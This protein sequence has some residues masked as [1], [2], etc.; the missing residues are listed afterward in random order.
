MKL[1]DY[2][3]S[4]K[5]KTIFNKMYLIVIF[6]IIII[7][8]THEFKTKSSKN[9]F[10]L[11]K[12]EF[13]SN[14]QENFTNKAASLN[15]E[16]YTKKGL[17]ELNICR[18]E[19]NANYNR[20]KRFKTCN[21]CDA[22][23]GCSWCNEKKAC[24]PSEFNYRN[25]EM[26]PICQGECIKLIKIEYCYKGLFEP[27]ITQHEIN[28]SNYKDVLEESDEKGSDNE[29][30]FEKELE[31][32]FLQIREGN[33]KKE[34]SEIKMNNTPNYQNYKSG[35]KDFN[36]KQKD[37]TFEDKN[38]D[39][40]PDKTDVTG[41]LRIAMNDPSINYIPNAFTNTPSQI[42]LEQSRKLMINKMNEI[43]KN[44]F[45][46][47][48]DGKLRQAS[49]PNFMPEPND[50]MKYLK[51]Y[52]PNFEFPQYVGS[53]LENSIDK[54]KKEKMLLWLRGYSLNQEISK[55]HLPIYK[56]LTYV[57][58]EAHRKMLLDKFYKDIVQE[59]R[60]KILKEKVES[61]KMDGHYLLPVTAITPETGVD[62]IKK[63][64]NYM[65][66]IVMEKTNADTLKNIKVINTKFVDKNDL[67]SMVKKNNMRF[68][69]KILSNKSN[70]NEQ[71]KE[72]K[73]KSLREISN[74]LKN[75]LENDL[76]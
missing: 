57:D 70:S 19:Y 62:I 7:E 26:V 68:K 30:I 16:Y 8:N 27:E 71:K 73:I 39:K 75:F 11:A 45:S 46:E 18:A 76:N 28:F 34:N 6:A 55:R 20:C 48:V 42:D 4:F 52:I 32:N 17:E 23:S 54:I 38:C 43:S 44:V 72:K 3:F 5:R 65:N 10:D 56:D 61:M 51:E 25:N 24:I 2:F 49:I 74:D 22:N 50:K 60:H 35:K 41:N 67:L 29:N 14:E 47:L 66:D 36:F 58:E 9:F 13:N 40:E 53:D 64:D 63:E 33:L 59:N 15:P 21:F 69:Q 31:K 1:V 12:E 37:K